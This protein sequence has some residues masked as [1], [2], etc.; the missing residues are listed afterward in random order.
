[1]DSEIFDCD[2]DSNP[3]P[4]NSLSAK[5][6]SWD[7]QNSFDKYTGSS[8]NPSKRKKTTASVQRNVTTASVETKMFDLAPYPE[9][10]ESKVRGCLRNTGNHSGISVQSILKGKGSSP[11]K[12]TPPIDLLNQSSKGKGKSSAN[13]FGF[14]LHPFLAKVSF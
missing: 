6:S 13:Q 1:M 4:Q 11:V 14:K 5:R 3:T 7:L 2:S 9:F 12:W 8:S 10:Q